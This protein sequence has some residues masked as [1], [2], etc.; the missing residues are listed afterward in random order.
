LTE[1]VDRL[2]LQFRFPLL[3]NGKRQTQ[4]ARHKVPGIRNAAMFHGAFSPA[5]QCVALHE[6]HSCKVELLSAPKDTGKALIN[7]E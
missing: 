1:P 7:H 6:Y 4:F 5:T 3:C 2:I